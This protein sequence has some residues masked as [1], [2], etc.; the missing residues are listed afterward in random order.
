[1]PVMNLKKLIFNE[2]AISNGNA[3]ALGESNK[4]LNGAAAHNEEKVE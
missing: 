4:A 2:S 1:M 3:A